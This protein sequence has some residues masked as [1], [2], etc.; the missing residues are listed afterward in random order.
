[1]H[2]SLAI[3]DNQYYPDTSTELSDKTEIGYSHP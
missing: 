3:I 2:D 1:M